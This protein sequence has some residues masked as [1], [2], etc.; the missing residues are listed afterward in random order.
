MSSRYRSAQAEP[1][2]RHGLQ[3]DRL[4]MEGSVPSEWYMIRVLPAAATNQ[5]PLAAA[6]CAAGLFVAALWLALRFGPALLRLTGFCSWWGAWAC[7]SQGG[8]GYCA[9][10]LI[11]GTLTWAGGTVWYARRRGRWPSAISER[12]L[13]RV[14]GRPSP[15]VPAK[16]SSD[17]AVM[18]PR[19][20]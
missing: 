19:R 5:G 2:A 15:L 9:A 17:S 3:F 7:G 4:T 16:P 11:L 18:P 20:Q 1:V 12:L 6:V 10:F 14:L 8:Y 13:T